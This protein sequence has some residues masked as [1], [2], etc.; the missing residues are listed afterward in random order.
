MGLLTFDWSQIAYLGS[1]LV[2]PWWAEV[3]VFF[4]FALAFWIIAPIMYYTNV[5][6]C[7]SLLSQDEIFLN[8]VFYSIGLGFSLPP[9][10]NV[11]S[12]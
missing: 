7:L 11:S 3:N 9:N 8:S 10:V 5:R 12:V 2:V 1:P 6:F 4:G